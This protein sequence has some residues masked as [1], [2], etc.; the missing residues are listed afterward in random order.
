M[1]LLSHCAYS[2][3][4]ESNSQLTMHLTQTND[5]VLV[6]ASERDTLRNAV[7]EH[8]AKEERLQAQL[9]ERDKGMSELKQVHDVE[10][11]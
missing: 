6:V 5:M 10:I 8:E 9:R 4:Q 3:L 7:Q 1:K 2:Q 11:R